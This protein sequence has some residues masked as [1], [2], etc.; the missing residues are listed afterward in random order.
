M[1][2]W[3]QFLWKLKQGICSSGHQYCQVTKQVDNLLCKMPCL[4]GFQTSVTSCTF[5]HRG[6]V[7][8]YV[9]ISL[10]CHPSYELA[11]G[12]EGARL[13]S[14]LYR[15]SR[16]LQGI[17]GQLM[18]SGTC[19]ASQ[20]KSKDQAHKCLLSS[21][22]QTCEKGFIKTFPIDMKDQIADA[23]AKALAQNDL[24]RYCRYMCGKWPP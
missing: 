6:W 12:N 5:N 21:F 17:W 11:W 9:T 3:C 1:L 15:T 13:P 23:L 19:K 8:C 14:H 16:V 4:M 24:Q 10:W 2:L 7:H 18:S 20:A 22:L